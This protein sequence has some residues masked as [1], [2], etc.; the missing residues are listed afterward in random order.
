MFWKVRG[1]GL[2]CFSWKFL[3]NFYLGFGTCRGIFA[4]VAEKI[5]LW[6]QIWKGKNPYWLSEIWLQLRRWSSLGFSQRDGNW[7][8]NTEELY[9]PFV[10]AYSHFQWKKDWSYLTQFDINFRW[11]L[12]LLFYLFIFFFVKFAELSVFIN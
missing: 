2:K 10:R 4:A 1:S 9:K 3:L 5:W 6:M 8:F 11:H 7:I 12:N